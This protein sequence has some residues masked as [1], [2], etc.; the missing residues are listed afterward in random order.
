ML[1]RVGKVTL[2]KCEKCDLGSGSWKV[3]GSFGSTPGCSSFSLR[4]ADDKPR[5]FEETI[6]K[7]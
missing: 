3:L 2:K 7:F 6:Q 1:S 5:N 4:A